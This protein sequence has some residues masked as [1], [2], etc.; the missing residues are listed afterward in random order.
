MKPVILDCCG[1]LPAHAYSQ[2]EL[3]QALEGLWNRQHFNPQR[4]RQL[5]EALGIGGRHLALPKERYLEGLNFT[6]ANQAYREVGLQLAVQ[7]LQQ[8]MQRSGVAWEQLGYL[9]FTSV[10]GLCV[11]SIDALLMNELPLPHHLRRL[12]I[13]GLGCLGGAAGIARL[14]DL[15]RGDPGGYGVLLSVELCSLTL[16]A[17]DVSVANLIATGLFGDGAAAVLMAGGSA[18]P[19]G[20]ARSG[21][22]RV[23]DTRSVFFPNSAHVMGWEIGSHG[24]SVVLSPEV[25]LYAR[26][27]LAPALLE[28]LGQHGLSL[29]AIGVWVAHPG[30]PKVIDALEQGLQLPEQTLQASRR[31]LAEIGNLS[32]ASVLFL[33]AEALAQPRPAGTYGLLLAM[34]PAFCA[35]VVLL[36]W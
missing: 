6:R 36:Q 24:F 17:E 13:F 20:S 27:H 19:G 3:S 31:S 5:H 11:P 16:Q 34:G 23:V 2:E 8:L 15:L 7:V 1:Q 10:T 18:M 9:V 12:P 26:Q 22:V 29:S 14:H 30:G 32:S 33:L 25:P 4:F 28:F 21:A 35:E